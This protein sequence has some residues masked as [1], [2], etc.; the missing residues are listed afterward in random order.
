MGV[1]PEYPMA[2][3]Q[4]D[5]YLAPP[6]GP[7]AS[8]ADAPAVVLPPGYQEHL[9][10]FLPRMPAWAARLE[11]WGAEDA[12]CVQ[13][14]HASGGRA[15]VRVRV[16]VR[17]PWSTFVRRI[18][19]FAQWAG[20]RLVMAEGRA[21]LPPDP[22]WISELVGASRPARYVADPD[23]YRRRVELGGLDDA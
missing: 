3:W 6:T 10:A 12:S 5:L 9:A 18:Y 19:A 22:E 11:L 23:L 21:P 7:V 17:R 4:C 2:A 1:D 13:L 15:V 8:G 14:W 16:D 20:C